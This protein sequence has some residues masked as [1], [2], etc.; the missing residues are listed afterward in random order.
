VCEYGIE[1][2]ALDMSNLGFPIGVQQRDKP[3][4]IPPYLLIQS[5]KPISLHTQTTK[6]C[7]GKRSLNGIMAIIAK[8]WSQSALELDFSLRC[9]MLDVVPRLRVRT[10]ACPRTPSS[11]C[12]SHLSVVLAH[13]FKTTPRRALPHSAPTFAS[14]AP[15][16]VPASSAPPARATRAPAT[17]ASH[18]QR[19][20][21]STEPLDSFPEE[22]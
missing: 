2:R 17:A 12:Q 8:I 14:Q 22:P 10:G 3:N 6:E 11:A 20:S 13:A 9:L 7:Q 5:A 1:I 4:F 19:P 18:F 15:P 21:A 16:L